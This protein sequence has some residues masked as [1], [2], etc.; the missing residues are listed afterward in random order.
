MYHK[1]R[2]GENL[3]IDGLTRPSDVAAWLG[4]NGFKVLNVAG[5][6]ESNWPGIGEKVERFLLAVFRQL[7]R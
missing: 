6:R 5:N 2:R 3:V 7:G 1:K 4:T